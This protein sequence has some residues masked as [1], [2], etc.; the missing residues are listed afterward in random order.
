VLISRARI[1]SFP[2]VLLHSLKTIPRIFRTFGFKV[3]L[4]QLYR[5]LFEDVTNR[6][7]DFQGELR[8]QR[9]DLNLLL[10]EIGNLA[11]AIEHYCQTE[12]HQV[13]DTNKIRRLQHSLISF[14]SDKG[15]NS[16]QLYMLYANIICRLREQRESV[17]L[18]EIGLG[19]NNVDIESNMGVFGSP[20]ANLRA[21][22]D[23]LRPQDLVFGADVD[24]RIL[25]QEQGICTYFVDQLE[26]GTISSLAKIIGS[27]DVIIDDGLHVLESNINTVPILLPILTQGGYYV[28]EDISNLPE[29]V[30]AWNAFSIHLT[31]LVFKSALI[32]SP[33][34][35]LG[36]LIKK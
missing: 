19:T 30:L 7:Y 29:N 36:F 27:A 9:N 26:P 24:R 11:V 21:F 4:T 20:G 13:A 10:T 31:R 14:G 35:S 33:S 3:G 25:F 6:Q 22:R 28:V 16:G 15:H 34:G 23:F 2:S 1:K 32:S 5:V 18:L 12:F 8:S 17:R